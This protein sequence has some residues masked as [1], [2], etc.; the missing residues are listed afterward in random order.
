MDG[1]GQI[2]DVLRANGSPYVVSVSIFN[3]LFDFLNFSLD[4]LRHEADYQLR[5]STRDRQEV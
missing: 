4:F 5:P 2:G 1:R 3:L